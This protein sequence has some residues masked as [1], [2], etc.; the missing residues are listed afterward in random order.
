MG[1]HCFMCCLLHRCCYPDSIHY[2]VALQCRSCVCWSRCRFGLRFS[3]DVSI[4]VRPQVDPW[5]RRRLLPMGYYH[6]S[7]PLQHCQQRDQ[8]STKPLVVSHPHCYPVYLGCGSRWWHD[9]PSRGAYF[10]AQSILCRIPLT[11][12]IAV[13]SL[14]DQ[15]SS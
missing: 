5:C 3:P 11:Q 14:A 13:P 6:R 7:P 4:R 15:T 2:T 12:A 1:H 8:E 9:P 10:R